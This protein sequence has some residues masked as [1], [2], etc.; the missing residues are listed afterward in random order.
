MC[1]K[2]GGGT[3]LLFVNG[4]PA[5]AGKLKR[6]AFRHG[7]EPFEVGRDSITPIAPDYKERSSFE[8]T[9]D[10]PE[11]YVCPVQEMTRHRQRRVES[12]QSPDTVGLK[13]VTSAWP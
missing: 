1:I 2:G 5:G 9:R 3:L 4:R 7:L 12:T 11:D 6:A 13:L 10:D 8:F